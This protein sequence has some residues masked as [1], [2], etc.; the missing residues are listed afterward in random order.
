MNT[1]YGFRMLITYAPGKSEL[2]DKEGQLMT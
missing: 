1:S 2:M